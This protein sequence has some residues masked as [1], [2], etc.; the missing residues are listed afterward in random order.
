MSRIRVAFDEHGNLDTNWLLSIRNAFIDITKEK[1]TLKSEFAHERKTFLIEVYS[2]LLAVWYTIKDKKSIDILYN[3]GVIT[4]EEYETVLSYYN[5]NLKTSFVVWWDNFEYNMINPTYSTLRK[6]WVGLEIYDWSFFDGNKASNDDIFKLEKLKVE[7]K[8]TIKKINRAKDIVT[9]NL[10]TNLALNTIAKDTLTVE[11][12]WIL[13]KIRANHKRTKF[14]I[15][16]EIAVYWEY[17]EDW[18]INN[19]IKIKEKKKTTHYR[20]S[21][22]FLF[23]IKKV[24]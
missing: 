1:N 12:K 19:I 13:Y 11:Y 22:L 16:D 4:D 7:V 18:K 15:W 20:W 3:I 23:F 17:G 6:A 8:A 10:T 9:T 2:N 5:N 21:C 14:K 24:E